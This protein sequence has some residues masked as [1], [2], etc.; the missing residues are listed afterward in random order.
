M[1]NINWLNTTVTRSTSVVPV[2]GFGMGE[3]RLMAAGVTSGTSS[4]KR[5][6]NAVKA[7]PVWARQP[8]RPPVT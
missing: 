6:A 2:H 5:H 3:V 8:W 7:N 1:S 4:L